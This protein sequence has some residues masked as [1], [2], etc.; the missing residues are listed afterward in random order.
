MRDD[1]QRA[2]VLPELAREPI[3]GLRIQ[4]IRR[5]V[6]QHVIGPAHQ[7]L[8]QRYLHPPATAEGTADLGAVR[9]LEPQA[10][11]DAVHARLDRVA[12]QQREVLVEVERF[13]HECR[14]V[15]TGVAQVR[16]DHRDAAGEREHVG[17]CHPH[18]LF[19]SVAGVEPRL[20]LQ[21]AQRAVAVAGAARR[22][23]IFPSQH[24]QQRGLAHAVGPD[25]RHALALRDIERNAREEVCATEGLGDIFSEQHGG[26]QRARWG[27]RKISDTPLCRTVP[28]PGE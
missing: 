24:A 7:H 9:L 6:Q 26:S 25:Q 1:H 12:V 16:L 2:Q 5:L 22:W 27:R 8:G 3:A 20:L 10:V 18:L 14:R 11:E 19:Q 28:R 17:E 15:V 13:G 23:L 21:V 4:M